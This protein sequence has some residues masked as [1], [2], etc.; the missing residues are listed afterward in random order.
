MHD[1]THVG[2]LGARPARAEALIQ[3]RHS[4][5]DRLARRRGRHHRWRRRRRHLQH[6]QRKVEVG[7]AL[8]DVDP[9]LAVAMLL[10]LDEEDAAAA[11]R[12][13]DACGL[14]VV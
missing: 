13:V 4:A 8:L 2:Q 5:T 1:H 10:S 7:A 11:R 6:M 14:A 9:S 3:R 12:G